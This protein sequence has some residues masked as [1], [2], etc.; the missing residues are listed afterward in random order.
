[1]LLVGYGLPV[2]FVMKKLLIKLFPRRDVNIQRTQFLLE[3][4]V[5][6][7]LVRRGTHF[8][9]LDNV[10]IPARE[11]EAH[12]RAVP[13][14][15]K[16]FSEPFDFYFVTKCEKKLFRFFKVAAIKPEFKLF[17]VRV[18]DLSGLHPDFGEEIIL[19]YA[20]I[21]RAVEVEGFLII[22]F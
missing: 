10:A 4:S 21:L 22:F 12:G 11:V 8:F 1:M 18:M 9:E 20:Q 13:I 7:F 3:R 15:F 19:L 14:E 6:F 17:A 16:P 2:F 5:F